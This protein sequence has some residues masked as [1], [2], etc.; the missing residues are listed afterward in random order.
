[1]VTHSL[2]RPALKILTKF[3]LNK[4]IITQI[5]RGVKIFFCKNIEIFINQHTRSDRNPKEKNTEKQK[6]QIPR[7]YYILCRN[8]RVK[9]IFSIFCVSMP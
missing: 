8:A 3:R 4:D 6:A 1:M 7:L 9:K 5:L 2:S